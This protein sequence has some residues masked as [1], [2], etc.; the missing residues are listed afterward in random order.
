MLAAAG[1]ACK[2]PAGSSS[3]TA[4]PSALV[5]ETPSSAAATTA[6]DADSPD[7]PGTGLGV[8]GQ[9]AVLPKSRPSCRSSD[10]EELPSPPVMGWYRYR[11]PGIFSA[12]LP[13]TPTRETGSGVAWMESQDRNGDYFLV[14]CGP[15]GQ[16]DAEHVGTFAGERARTKGPA[17]T[18]AS[19]PSEGRVS[20]LGSGGLPFVDGTIA[21][22]GV[23]A[24]T[25]GAEYR[26]RSVLL[27]GCS[28]TWIGIAKTSKGVANERSF[29]NS[30]W[31][32]P[33]LVR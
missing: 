29:A 24:Y 4:G 14:A 6:P 3:G 10:W 16:S 12:L 30:F 20:L 19:T 1:V 26:E 9:N 27:G 21:T 22:E 28:C 15:S 17:L 33:T 13:Q 7:A 8:F 2:Q 18:G 11:V 31:A 25:N 5:A 23:R 32:E